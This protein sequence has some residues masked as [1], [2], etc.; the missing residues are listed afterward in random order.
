M[1]GPRK[2]SS[3]ITKLKLSSKGAEEK[4]K[5]SVKAGGGQADVDTEKINSESNVEVLKERLGC[6]W[7][8]NEI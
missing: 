8:E 1:S 3:I 6:F 2:W 5:E 4:G 7:Q